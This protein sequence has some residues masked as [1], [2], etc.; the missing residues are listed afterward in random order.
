MMPFPIMPQ[1]NY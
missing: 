1:S